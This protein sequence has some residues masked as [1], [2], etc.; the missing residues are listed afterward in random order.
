MPPVMRSASTYLIGAFG[1]YRGRALQP[2]DILSV[3][4]IQRHL[5]SLAGRQLG[6]H[7]P[8]YSDHP[9]VRVVLGPQDEYFTPDA[10]ETLLSQEYQGSTTSDRM[11]L[12]LQGPP[13][14]H[15][16]AKEMVS[17][18]IAPGSIQVPPDAQPIV[19]MADRQSV[20]GYPL[21]ATIIRSDIPL[22]AQCL[23]GQSSVRFQAISVE[24][25]Q[26]IYRAEQNRWRP[27][28]LEQDAIAF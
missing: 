2:G 23:P 21:I 7:R 19:L 4:R 10:I 9:V 1:G 6:E 27:E 17:S 15:K 26:S 8:G 22:L 24:E 12:R 13:L 20:G 14:I 28:G 11:G 18:G 25:A 3:G 16:G 5:P